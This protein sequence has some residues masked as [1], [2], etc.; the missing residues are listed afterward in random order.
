MNET[1]G[2]IFATTGKEYT[3]LATRAAQSV[4]E[5]CPGLE[6]DLFT[7]QQVDMPVFDRI[8]QLEDPWR[9]S[10]IDAMAASR[11]E[12]T[13]YLDAD[14][15]VVSDIRDVFEVLDR[16]DI[17][18][19]HDESRNGDHA[20]RIWRKPLPNAFPQFNTGVIAFRR[21]SKVIELFKSWSVA[22]RENDFKGDQR[23]MRELLWESDLRVATLPREYNLMRLKMLY[24]WD[25]QQGAP[26][27]IHNRKLH[28]H[29]TEN[30]TRLSSLQDLLGPLITSKLP[31]LLSADKGLARMSGREPHFPSK[32]ET[33]FRH[34]S[35]IRDIP[36]HLLRRLQ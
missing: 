27:I 16:F 2:A 8:Q 20:Q 7:D 23:M 3:E 28:K 15:F 21:D 5:N 22:V 9:R 14:L 31:V 35:L 24:L 18:L 12:R 34:L 13:L 25:I 32:R 19:A 36:W 26:R 1:I 33:F 4:K 6:V 17:A 10:K 29:F 11:F 30:K